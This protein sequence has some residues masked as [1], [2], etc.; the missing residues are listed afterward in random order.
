MLS[1]LSVTSKKQKSEKTLVVPVFSVYAAVTGTLAAQHVHLE[2]RQTAGGSSVASVEALSQNGED[3]STLSVVTHDFFCLICVHSILQVRRAE[4]SI[5]GQKRNSS[6]KPEM[7]C[8]LSD[9]EVFLLVLNSRISEHLLL[10]GFDY[11]HA[12]IQ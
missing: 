3:Q 11:Y 2:R 6:K 5:C 4:H 9:D 10:L 7:N 12:S 1:G 8:F